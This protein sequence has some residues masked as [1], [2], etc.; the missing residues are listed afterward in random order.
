MFNCKKTLSVA[1]VGI[2]IGQCSCFADGKDV[3]VEKMKQYEKYKDVLLDSSEVPKA[4]KKKTIS[5]S[6]TRGIGATGEPLTVEGF[7]QEYECQDSSV[8]T[9]LQYGRFADTNAAEEAL[10]FHV[11]NV[12]ALFQSEPW[13]DVHLAKEPDK[14]LFSTNGTSCTI[15]FRDGET[16]ILISARG[17]SIAERR[18]KAVFFADKIIGRLKAGRT[19]KN[20]D[21]SGS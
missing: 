6:W 8:T 20:G 17:G 5:R 12:A 21:A 7:V 4:S 15:A 9:R 18:K 14:I 10:V 13:P 3:P 19:H 2:M 1:I 16:C 11:T